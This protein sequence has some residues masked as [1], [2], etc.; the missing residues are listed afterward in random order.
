[1]KAKSGKYIYV[2]S[3]D[4]DNSGKVESAKPHYVYVIDTVLG[5]DGYCDGVFDK[6]NNLKEIKVYY[7]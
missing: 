3:L 6:L 7:L 2:G 4:I 1:M 5:D